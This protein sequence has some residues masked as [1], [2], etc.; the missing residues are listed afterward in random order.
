MGKNREMRGGCPVG[1]RRNPLTGNCIKKCKMG[2]GHIEFTRKKGKRKGKM[3][4]TCRKRRLV[5]APNRLARY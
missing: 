1:R 2:Y 4:Y 5:M 3:I